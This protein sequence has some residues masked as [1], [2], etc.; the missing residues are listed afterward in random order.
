MAKNKTKIKT[1]Y[2]I[3]FDKLDARIPDLPDDIDSWVHNVLF[4]NRNYFFTKTERGIKSGICT[5]CQIKSQISP[6]EKKTITPED[7]EHISTKHN[8]LSTCPH[9]GKQVQFKD[10]GR[11][12][13]NLIDYGYFYILQPVKY[14]GVVLRTFYCR[15][16]WANVN[17]FEYNK[18]PQIEYS[19]HFRIFMHK[20]THACFKRTAYT[21]GYLYSYWSKMNSIA[22]P[23]AHYKDAYSNIEFNEVTYHP[24]NWKKIISQTEYKYSCL[25]EWAYRPSYAG[26]YLELYSKYPVLVERL[27]KQGYRTV[28][29]DKIIGNQATYGIINFNKETPA[30]AFKLSKATLSSIG[31]KLTI[32]DIA[33][34]S[35]LEHNKCSEKTVEYVNSLQG[36]SLKKFKSICKFLNSIANAN[37]ICKYTRQQSRISERYEDSILFDYYDYI[38]QIKK[39]SLPVNTGTAFPPNLVKAHSQTTTMLNELKMEAERK[40]LEEIDKD[41]E[42]QY[43]KLCKKYAYENEYFIVRPA[44]GK[45]EL[46]VE[47]STLHHCVYSNYAD[48]YLSGNVLIILIRKKDN[49]DTPFY[50]LELNPKTNAVIQCRTLYNRSYTENKAVSVLMKE[51]LEFLALPKKEQN[52][53]RQQHT[54]A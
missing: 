37:K 49:P 5:H 47:G 52:K 10:N 7:L 12:R 21:Y 2:D 3:D 24:E 39:L 30:E 20:N 23:W 48:R 51:Y 1:A 13:G 25:D 4:A 11:S 14:G 53:I 35:F 9:C 28:L 34:T 42:P 15:R 29:E 54:A 26:K 32:L 16:E 18:I 19:E 40:K 44:K 27:M 45:Q 50:T 6:L 46:F 31:K 8:K 38:Q 41:F 33:K 22:V 43:Q 36:G 17:L